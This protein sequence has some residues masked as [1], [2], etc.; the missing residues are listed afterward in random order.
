MSSIAASAST[1][2]SSEAAAEKHG[3]KWRIQRA[4]RRREV[5]FLHRSRKSQEQEQ[6]F[7]MS[8]N[9]SLE[10]TIFGTKSFIMS[11]SQQLARRML[12]EDCS[13]IHPT[14]IS[15]M[16]PAFMKF[17]YGNRWF[18]RVEMYSTLG[19]CIVGSVAIAASRDGSGL[20]HLNDPFLYPFPIPCGIE[21][22]AEGAPCISTDGWVSWADLQRAA[23]GRG[24]LAVCTATA[25]FPFRLS[26]PFKSFSDEDS[27]AGVW[28]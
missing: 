17:M 16:V 8:A 10:V 23:E 4:V 18:L 20:L 13:R 15:S 7:G 28:H 26:C 5:I 21:L 3:Y 14:E 6:E 1:E 9:N 25:D 19:G 11:V 22:T 27:D 24:P 12:E 2:S